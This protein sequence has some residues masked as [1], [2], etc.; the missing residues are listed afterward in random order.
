M[1]DKLKGI[2]LRAHYLGFGAAVLG[3]LVLGGVLLREAQHDVDQMAMLEVHLA[4]PR[5]VAVWSDGRVTTIPAEQVEVAKRMGDMVADAES[6]RVWRSINKDQRLLAIL[7]GFLVPV[8]YL[9]VVSTVRWLFVGK[10]SLG[11]RLT[12]REIDE[13]DTLPLRPHR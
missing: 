8:A 5:R 13:K 9:L 12:K 4:D 10:F 7:L 11:F 3:G 1:N 6:L 2:L